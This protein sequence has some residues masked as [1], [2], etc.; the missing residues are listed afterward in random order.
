MIVTQA[1]RTFYFTW[2]LMKAVKYYL[3]NMI[4]EKEVSYSL[5]A[6]FKILT[7][8]ITT[9]QKEAINSLGKQDGDTW[10]REYTDRDYQV[11]ASVLTRM[12]DMNESQRAILEEFTEQLCKGEI[13]A[14][15][16]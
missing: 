4:D 15:A 1:A 10:Q 12:V 14:V 16:A 3:G 8:R 9:L 2:A 5:K 7:N 11:F 13:K 6:E